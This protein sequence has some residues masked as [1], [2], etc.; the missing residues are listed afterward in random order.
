VWVLWCCFSAVDLFIDDISASRVDSSSS[1]SIPEEPP[2][3]TPAP[4]EEL[5]VV[6]I[7]RRLRFGWGR[8][9]RRAKD[10]WLGYSILL[11]ADGHLSK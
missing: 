5:V 3:R 2:N 11:P 7:E 1:G 8:A 9:G 10:R 4:V 6:M